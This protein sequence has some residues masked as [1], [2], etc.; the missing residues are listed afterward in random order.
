MNRKAVLLAAAVA[1]ILPASLYGQTWVQTAVGT[2]DWANDANWTPAPYPNAVGA[3]ANLTNDIVGEQDVTIPTAGAGGITIGVLNIG[4]GGASPDS[5]WDLSFNSLLTFDNGTS[6]AQIN[7]IKDTTGI[8]GWDVIWCVDI[9][10]NS[11][12][13]VNAGPT[14]ASTLRINGTISDGANGPRKLIKTGPGFL[15]IGQ[16]GLHQAWTGGTVLSEG[17]IR[18]NIGGGYNLLPGNIDIS[19]GA[20]LQGATGNG[21]GIA[22][23]AVIGFSG[24]GYYNPGFDSVD[25]VETIGGFQGNVAGVEDVQIGGGAGSIRFGG[26][27]LDHVFNG[28]IG[29]STSYVKIGTGVQELGGTLGSWQSSGTRIFGVLRGRVDLN[30]TAGVTAVAQSLVNIG[31]ATFIGIE[32]PELRLLQSEQIQVNTFDAVPAETSTITMNSGVF[33]L[34]GNT[35]TVGSIVIT[36]GIST[37]DH[38]VGGKLAVVNGLTVDAGATLELKGGEAVAFDIGA[39]TIN[40]KIDLGTGKLV[41]SSPAGTF[42]GAAYDGVAGQVDLARGDAG[43]AQWNGPSGITTSD[44]R[45]INNGDLISIGVAKVGDVRTVADTETTTFAGQTVLGSDTLVMATWGGD[46]NLDGKINIDDYGRIDGNVGQSG[47]VFGWSKGDFNYDGKINIDDYG[48][49]DG[50]INRQGAPFTTGAGVEGVAAV[51]EPMSLS[52]LALGAMGLMR[53]RR[54]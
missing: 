28:R 38:G 6:N 15:E 11:D 52:L 22:D 53:R 4:D 29:S 49:I 9:K 30:K 8:N 48:I 19:G 2:Y 7:S 54:K 3:V 35:E 16:V 14:A 33:N 41:T 44:T 40:G 36:G 13:V 20:T 5:K 43:N 51:P 45:A 42:V 50:N 39:A 37:I 32:R 21:E 27:N 47:S 17:R 46:A 23:T 24:L 1:G 18:L 34:N 12:L 26:D 31:D 10:L 25:D